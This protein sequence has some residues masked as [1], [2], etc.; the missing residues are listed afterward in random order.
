MHVANEGRKLSQFA[1][2]DDHVYGEEKCKWQNLTS[3][4]FSIGKNDTEQTKYQN[5]DIHH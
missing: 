4:S 5:G 3:T 1:N 2:S